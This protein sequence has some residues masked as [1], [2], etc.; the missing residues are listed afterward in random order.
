MGIPGVDWVGLSMAF[1]D[2]TVAAHQNSVDHGF[3]EGEQNVSEK[4]CLVHS[5]VSEALEEYR[6]G[7]PL[8]GL[9]FSD[10]GKPEGF[11]VELADACIRIFD[12]A[13][14]YGI[15]LSDCLKQKMAYNSTRAHKHGGK[16]C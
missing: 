1:E 10:Q 13:G 14:R 2:L 9:R 5:E 4:L 8:S 16:K 15:N 3:W 6:A 7:H 12:L 11:G